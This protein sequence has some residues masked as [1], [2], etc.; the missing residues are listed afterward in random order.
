MRFSAGGTSLL[1]LLV[2]IEDSHCNLLTTN[3]PRPIPYISGQQPLTNA[4]AML[5]IGG[6]RGKVQAKRHG[7]PAKKAVLRRPSAARSGLGF[8]IC[9]GP[10]QVDRPLSVDTIGMSLR[11]W[12]L[13]ADRTGEPYALKMK[14]DHVKEPSQGRRA[15]A[16]KHLTVTA[17]CLPSAPCW[18]AGRCTF[19]AKM[20]YDA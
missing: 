12:W 13:N 5:R 20:E 8:V 9:E 15:P 16:L 3:V 14:V 11:N 1:P 2:S 17:R 6:K 10:A 19:A 18:R 4:G 7:G